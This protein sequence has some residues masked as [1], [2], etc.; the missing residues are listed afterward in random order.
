MRT[1]IFRKI[2][3]RVFI[4]IL[5]LIFLNIL[6][7]YSLN[8]TNQIHSIIEKK[9]VFTPLEVL[10]GDTLQTDTLNQQIHDMPGG[11]SVNYT[12]EQ[13]SAYYRAMKIKIP[14][15]TRLN[16][17]L[18]V[19]A[20]N[21]AIQQKIN[22]GAPFQMMMANLNSIPVQMLTPSGQ[23]I[24]QYQMSISNSMYVPGVKTLDSRYAVAS[25]GTILTLLGLKEDVSPKISYTLDYSD[26]VEIVIYS[27]NAT[28]VAVLFNN[29]QPAGSY[30]MN[31]NFR[32]DKGRRMA[33]GDYIAEVRIGKSKFIRKR[34]VIP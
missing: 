21:W 9:R 17:D 1:N 28:V 29:P 27:V 30:T 19:T 3:E 25:L 18:R 6:P 11:P 23:E 5:S 31:W 13:D 32:D 14:V 24:V 34:I 26:D 8:D 2:F 12:I 20:N 15:V 4:I 22:E 10:K 7:S 16:N 33:P